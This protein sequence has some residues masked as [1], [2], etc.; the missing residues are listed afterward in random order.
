[1]LRARLT[2]VR[3]R[4]EARLDLCGFL[5]AP[6]ARILVAIARVA[7]CGGV[8][9][10]RRLRGVRRSIVHVK[11]LLPKTGKRP[12]AEVGSPHWA[13]SATG[14]SVRRPNHA[15]A[16]N[17]RPRRD[18]EKDGRHYRR[19][20]AAPPHH[21]HDTAVTVLGNFER[22][23]VPRKRGDESGDLPAPDRAVAA[24]CA[25]TCS[26]EQSGRVTRAKD[27]CRRPGFHGWSHA[28]TWRAVGGS[29]QGPSSSAAG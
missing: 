2:E 4:A 6:Y 8:G 7:G 14:S 18:E 22:T 16:T 12:T 13:I 27:H 11:R 9:G 24:Q 10:A 23:G 17:R 3:E 1:V 5:N 25:R 29:H 21:F 20:E 15:R 26:I 19:A 28:G